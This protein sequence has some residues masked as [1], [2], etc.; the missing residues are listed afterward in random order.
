MSI[1]DTLCTLVPKDAVIE[2]IAVGIFWTFVR[3]QY[4]CAI[5]ASAHRWYPD[6]PGAIIPGAGTLCG[7]PV[8]DLA[9]LYQSE[10]LTAR[11]L[12]NAAVSASFDATQM[13]GS[14]FPGKAQTLLE[15]LC[16]G[17]TRH[18]ALIGHF[19]FADELRAM[20]HKLDIYELDGRCEPGDI[21]SSRI[22]QYLP[23]ADIVIMTSS[24]LITHATEQ[25]LSACSQNA[26]KMIVG[27]TVPIHPV[28]W[29]FGFDAICGSVITDPNQV[30]AT[31]REGG[32]HKQMTGAQKL[33]FIRPGMNSQCAMRN[34]E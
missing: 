25:I 24:T 16:A 21:P 17:Q 14:V 30:S 32:N 18:I 34:S 3:T 1:F 10:S 5:S 31:A 28:L 26:F 12:A 13:T 9:P 11:S 27:P 2:D 15:S 29:D 22:P 20:G 33:N 4:G 19:H 6:P 8:L 23:D 7:T